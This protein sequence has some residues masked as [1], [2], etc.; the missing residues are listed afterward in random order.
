[1][2]ST[3]VT[4]PTDHNPAAWL[5]LR[6]NPLPS[7]PETARNILEAT[8][9]IDASWV[10]FDNIDINKMVGV[11]KK[12][13]LVP[14]KKLPGLEISS[15]I[16]PSEDQ[17]LSRVT[18]IHREWR[19][20]IDLQ[21]SMDSVRIRF[22]AQYFHEWEPLYNELYL[23]AKQANTN[24]PAQAYVV[25]QT[26]EG[27]G[28]HEFELVQPSESIPLDL[29]YGPGFG[30]WSDQLVA[31]LSSTT[32]GILILHGIPGSGKTSYIRMLMQKLGPK[33][34]PLFVTRSLARELGSPQLATLLLSLAHKDR[35]IVLILEDAEHM[36]LSRHTSDPA[37]ADLVSLILNLTDG[38][39]NDLCRCQVIATFNTDIKD[40]D[41]AVMRRGRLIGEREFGLLD[42][43]TVNKLLDYLH[44]DNVPDIKEPM[45]LC[46]VLALS[47]DSTDKGTKTI[48]PV[49]SSRKVGF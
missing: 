43:P 27:L 14:T 24:R 47:R 20:L 40:V 22:D 10:E 7:C 4:V 29:S 25:T 13:L 46:D 21:L 1:M 32:S 39:L 49:H 44:A 31:K 2:T 34:Y 6:V 12:Y 3:P 48:Q 15:W 30:D 16:V 23:M 5:G 37:G 41:T 9:N 26:S 35:D 42:A 18:L 17:E 19:I 8:Y 45:A 11:I 38:L 28:T 33:K 36:L